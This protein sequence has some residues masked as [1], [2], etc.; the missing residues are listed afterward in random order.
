[1]TGEAWEIDGVIGSRM[2]SGGFDGYTVSLVK[3]K[4]INTFIKEVGAAYVAKIGI[5]LK[6]YITE[7]E[8]G[9]CKLN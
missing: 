1:M 9:V 8:N 3:S 5:M 6:F 2:T 7:I 4:A